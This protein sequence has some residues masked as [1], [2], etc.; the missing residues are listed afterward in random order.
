MLE[1]GQPFPFGMEKISSEQA[2]NELN[3]KYYSL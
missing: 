3:E 1:F 2:G